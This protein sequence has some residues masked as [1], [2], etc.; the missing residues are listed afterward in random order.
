MI[1]LGVLTDGR[2]DCLAAGMDTVHRLGKFDHRFI[3]D[4]SGD[5]SYAQWLKASY[6]DFT[7]YRNQRRLGLA[8]AVEAV[9]RHALA[10]GAD[11]L[12][13][14]EDDFE[15]LEHVD[16]NRIAAT[17]SGEPDVAQMLL[18]WQPLAPTEVAA[19][20]ILGGM[21]P[22]DTHVGWV[23]QQTIFSLNPCIIP[24]WVLELG[25][26]AGNEAEMTQILLRQGARFGVWGEPGSASLVRHANAP[27][28]A[29]WAL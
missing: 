4:D 5:D 27:R 22:Y 6:K 28:T 17:L 23:T 7:V 12:F 10:T 29:A 19:G 25:W 1:A 26:P 2:A 3:V 18:K 16:V 13:H 21:H 14:L 11:Y 15:V 24:R 20:D 8:G 9:W